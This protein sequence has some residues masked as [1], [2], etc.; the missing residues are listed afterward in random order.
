MCPNRAQIRVGDNIN[1]IYDTMPKK[2]LTHQFIEALNAPEK[3]TTYYDKKEKGLQLRISK[4]G[5]K[6]FTYRYYYN[7]KQRRYKIGTFPEKSLSQARKDVTG[8]K[9]KVDEGID[10]Q[11][12]RNKLKYHADPKTFKE[13]AIEF[14]EKYLPTLRESTRKEYERIIDKELIPSL[15]DTPIDDISKN[16]IISLLDA[17]AYGTGKAEPAPTMAN[18]IRARLSRIFTFGMERG[19]AEKNPVQFTSTYKEGETKRDRFY[20][21]KEIQ[22]LWKYF[23]QF[24][25]PTQSV[26]KMLLSTGQRKGET[27]KMKW[28]DIKSDVWTIPAELAKNKQAH[29]VPLSEM[30]LQI[31]EDMRP[32]TG[33][34]DY[35]FC[36]PKEDNA[37]MKWLTRAREFIKDNSKIPDFRPH[38]LRR[39]FATYC[40]K[41]GVDRTVLGKILNHK[42]L[43]GDGQ[44][45]AIY[46]RHSYMKEKRQAMNRWSSYLQKILA[47]ETEAN[48]TKIG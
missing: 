3:P 31:I 19:L 13:L 10:P 48:I 32:I 16:Q 29:D 36:S 1:Q 5:T 46:D 37:P 14:K 35:V 15:G 11:A 43:A 42:G 34:T 24:N 22:E 9:A 2:K 23:E 30:A 47:D 7:D 21:V 28:E 40:S 17:K 6:T 41:L 38:D 27:M 39:T 18:R 45:T 4:A 12:E 33:E 20:S 26:F 8:I 25:E 44:V